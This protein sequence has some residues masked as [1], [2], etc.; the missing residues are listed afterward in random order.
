MKVIDTSLCQVHVLVC[1]NERPAPKSCCKTVGGEDFYFRLK[2]SLKDKGLRPTHWATRTGCLGYCN[3]TG[4]TVA[5]YRR[6]EVPQ[7]FTEVTSDEFDE[8]WNQVVKG[9]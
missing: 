4:C 6:G 3:A 9:L 1:T 7:W 5:I 2:N 8:I